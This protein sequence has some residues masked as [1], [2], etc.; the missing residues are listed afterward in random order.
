MIRVQA[1]PTWRCNYYDF[2]KGAAHGRN[3]GYCNLFAPMV[4][5]NTHAFFY[6]KVLPIKRELVAEEWIAGA[7]RAHTA[8]GRIL[9]DFT[10]G[11]PTLYDGLPA[12]LAGV[13]D[14]SDWAITS[15]SILWPRIEALFT[16]TGVA[17]CSS[18][19]A[20][21][22]P[23]A[24]HS[25]DE[26]IRNLY[27]IRKHSEYVSVTMV[28]HQTTKHCIK[29]HLER[30]AAEGFPRQVHMFEGGISSD[31]IP[32]GQPGQQANLAPKDDADLCAVAAEIMHLTRAPSDDWAR[33]PSDFPPP[34]DCTAGQQSVAVSSDGA[35]HLCYEHLVHQQSP[36]IGWWGEWEP[37]REP[38]RGCTW[39][40]VFG[41]DLRNIVKKT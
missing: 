29:G 8:A 5:A 39:N 12:L 37:A 17:R 32:G 33:V 18:W 20:S 38:H 4:R 3:C 24:G 7:K 34:N 41:C 2:R 21:W 1:V 13:K 31:G 9:W 16:H 40:C 14:I 11:E 6:G 36:Q 10:G 28:L 23:L 27:Y 25:I 30:F 22:H 35:V 26:F 15:N 19:T